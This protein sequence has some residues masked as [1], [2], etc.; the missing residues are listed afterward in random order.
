MVRPVPASIGV[1][2]PYGVKYQNGTIHKGV[3]YSNGHEGNPIYAITD[4]LVV[5]AGLNS[6]TGWGSAYGNHMIY[7]TTFNGKKKWVLFGHM[8]EIDVKV[9][10]KVKAGQKIGLNG[11]KPGAWYSGNVTGPHVH[12]QVCHAN[13]YLAYEDPKPLIDSKP[14][15]VVPPVKYEYV[16]VKVSY[17]NVAGYN[18]A[19][20]PGVTGFKTHIPNIAKAVI[21]DKAEIFAVCELSNKAK[22]KMLPLLDSS[23]KGHLARVPKGSDGRWFYADPDIKIIA[24]GVVTCAKS[25]WYLKDDKQAA[26][27]VFEKDGAV[28]AMMVYQLAYQNGATPDHL[29]VMQALDFLAQFKGIVAKYKVDPENTYIGGDTNSEGLV[30]RGMEDHGYNTF[31]VNDP[32]FNGWSDGRNT[33]I[34]WWYRLG[35]ASGYNV[36]KSKDSDHNRLRFTI[37]LRK[38]A[39]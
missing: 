20:A 31:G 21:A 24:S 5:H 19:S 10:Q 25:T 4:G 11:G 3:D 32:T 18:A 28:G 7:T 2:F 12:V 38:V 23:L 29:R 17:Q 35:K 8:K 9:G 39:S 16:P 6:A 14:P 15:V 30:T 33:H 22:P 34:D 13:N 37:S 1:S 36:V 27:F 26:W